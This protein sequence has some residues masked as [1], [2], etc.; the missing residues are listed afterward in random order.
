M[1]VLVFPVE[2]HG[3]KRLEN[4][5][6]YILDEMWCNTDKVQWKTDTKGDM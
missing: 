4:M 2:K 5:F 3:H 1:C 6:S